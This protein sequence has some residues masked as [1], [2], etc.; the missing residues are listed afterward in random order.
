MLCVVGLT[1]WRIAVD[2]RRWA[3]GVQRDR[4]G[5]TQVYVMPNP[6]G[7]NADVT[8]AGLTAEFRAVADLADAEPADD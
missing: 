5:R 2:R 6:S 8:T 1:G 4:I 3:T 7:L